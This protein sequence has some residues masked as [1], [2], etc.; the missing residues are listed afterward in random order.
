[1]WA[2]DISGSG[3]Y[4]PGNTLIGDAAGN[5]TKWFGGTSGAT[6]QVAGLAGLVLSVN[7]DL[8]SNE[9]QSIIESTADDVNDSGGRDDEYG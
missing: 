4:N 3:G 1:L 5:Y 9:V 8:D 2:T 6:P 7:P